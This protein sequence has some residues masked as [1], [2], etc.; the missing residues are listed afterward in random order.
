MANLFN[1]TED[2]FRPFDITTGQRKSIDDPSVIEMP[3][4][5]IGTGA[6]VGPDVYF[7]EDLNNTIK[8]T[9]ENAQLGTELF[10]MKLP[11]S[12]VDTFVNKNIEQIG[13]LQPDSQRIWNQPELIPK[14][15]R[16][17]LALEHLI[18]K[19]LGKGD[20]K[21]DSNFNELEYG[22]AVSGFIANALS[23]KGIKA[24]ANEKEKID[25]RKI[26]WC[27]SYIHHIL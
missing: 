27:A 14:V 5:M 21:F 10:P 4:T 2:A 8:K 13:T 7:P 15:F 22:T 3:P 11:P 20:F 26:W 1:Q 12:N 9:M 17:V 19:D 24:Y 6:T 25:P 16:T 18:R 23:G